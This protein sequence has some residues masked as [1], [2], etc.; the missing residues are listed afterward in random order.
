[1]TSLGDGLT[2]LRPSSAGT[3]TPACASATRPSKRALALTAV[4]EGSRHDQ[5]ATHVRP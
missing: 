5:L 4:R 3:D 1:M 2:Q